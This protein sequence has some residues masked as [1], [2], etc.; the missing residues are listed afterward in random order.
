MMIGIEMTKQFNMEDLIKAS[1]GSD[2]ETFNK[3]AKAHGKKT[4]VI[5]SYKSRQ[6]ELRLFEVGAYF[7]VCIFKR[8]RIIH[9]SL[10]IDSKIESFIY[11]NKKKKW[12]LLQPYP[13]IFIIQILLSIVLLVFIV[14]L[15]IINY[16]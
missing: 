3:I 5:Y 4:K 6:R 14:S 8:K 15:I 12:L 7:V 2:L 1:S 11:L 16:V 9:M 10:P 13:M